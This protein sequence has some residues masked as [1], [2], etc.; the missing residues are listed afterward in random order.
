MANVTQLLT[1]AR[2]GNA[3]AIAAVMSRPLHKDGVSVQ[4]NRDRSEGLVIAFLGILAP[5]QRQIL[6]YVKRGLDKLGLSQVEPQVTVEGWAMGD[7]EPDWRVTMPLAA[8]GALPTTDDLDEAKAP[9]TTVKRTLKEDPVEDTEVK[10][11]GDG[12]AITKT[13]PPQPA[14]KSTAPP[15]KPVQPPQPKMNFAELQKI[16][17]QVVETAIQPTVAPTDDNFSADALG[18]DPTVETSIESVAASNS[19]PAKPTAP[20]RKTLDEAFELLEASISQVQSRNLPVDQVAVSTKV[21]LG[22][23]SLEIQLD[24]PSQGAPRVMKLDVQGDAAALAK[25]ADQQEDAAEDEAGTETPAIAEEGEFTQNEAIWSAEEQPKPDQEPE[26][27]SA[28][29]LTEGG[30]EGGSSETIAEESDAEDSE[31]PEENQDPLDKARSLLESKRFD[32]A[33]AFLNPLVEA[34]IHWAEAYRLLS[35]GFFG[36]GKEPEGLLSLKVARN[37]YIQQGQMASALQVD[38]IFVQRNFNADGP[39][40]DWVVGMVLYNQGKVDEA[41]STLQKTA[42]TNPEEPE[43]LKILGGIFGKQGKIE[44]GKA[45]LRKAQTLYLKKGN[46]DAAREIESFLQTFSQAQ[47]PPEATAPA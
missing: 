11:A 44:E 25:D 33:I 32:E 14:V 21:D 19:A 12:G 20:P 31:A 4:V 9:K 8:P 2:Q 45:T 28:S 46:T 30:T 3:E 26:A 34:N 18:L 24:V 6:G 5:D 38:Q 13:T 22:P 7:S 27:P 10:N 43:P 16:V 36:Q 40:F 29:P 42:Q 41:I 39:E 35:A 47:T 23:I 37:L 1:L 15:P 17:G